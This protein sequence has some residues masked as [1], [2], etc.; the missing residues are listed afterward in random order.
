MKKN[1]MKIGK[2]NSEFLAYMRQVMNKAWAYVKE[3][4]MTFVEALKL[5]WKWLKLTI[6]MKQSNVSFSYLKVDGTTIRNAIGT[7][8]PE[9]LPAQKSN[10]GRKVKLINFRYFDLD[11]NEWRSFNINNLLT[12]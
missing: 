6:K 8:R 10:R 7:L 3:C 9:V 4:S 2:N 1:T 11:K 5:A 12:F